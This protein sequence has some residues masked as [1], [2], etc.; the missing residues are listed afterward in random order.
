VEQKRLKILRQRTKKHDSIGDKVLH[1][2][3]GKNVR[4]QI[5]TE[6][7]QASC[8]YSSEQCTYRNMRARFRI[9]QHGK[10]T[11]IYDAVGYSGS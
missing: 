9:E 6:L 7:L 4:V 2:Y 1:F 5:E 8:N 10:P 11:L 3:E